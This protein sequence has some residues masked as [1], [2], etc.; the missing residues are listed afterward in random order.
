LGEDVRNANCC[1]KRKAYII[2]V[3]QYIWREFGG[4]GID[5]RKEDY[6]NSN[7]ESEQGVPGFRFGK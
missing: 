6:K 5:R 7:Y 4:P 2:K 1:R 3:I